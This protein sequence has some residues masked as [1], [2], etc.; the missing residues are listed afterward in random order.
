M[1]WLEFLAH[2]A[3]RL[4]DVQT[5]PLL[6]DNRCPNSKSFFLSVASTTPSSRFICC[7]TE[8]F[9]NSQGT[10]DANVNVCWFSVNFLL[11]DPVKFNLRRKTCEKL[12]VSTVGVK[13]V[14]HSH[15]PPKQKFRSFVPLRRRTTYTP[16]KTIRCTGRTTR[17]A[18]FHWLTG[19]AFR[20][21]PQSEPNEQCPWF[22]GFVLS[23]DRP[24]SV[25]DREDRGDNTLPILFAISRLG[26]HSAS[27]L[28]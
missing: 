11:V 15:F 23:W 12:S 1:T 4:Y 17:G 2:A 10:I 19:S 5:M 18:V 6:T 20:G 7:W 26:F 22:V 21:L 24:F 28:K 27:Q 13:I 9:P 14:Y 8:T 25:W 3:S 16:M